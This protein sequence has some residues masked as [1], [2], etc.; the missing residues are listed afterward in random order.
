[1]NHERDLVFFVSSVLVLCL[2]FFFFFSKFRILVSH[3]VKRNKD[4]RK[5]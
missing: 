3:T 2:V 5:E 1:M 4:K